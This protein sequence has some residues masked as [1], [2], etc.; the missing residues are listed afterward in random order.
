MITIHVRYHNILQRGAGT[1]CETVELP[2]GASLAEALRHLADQH[3]AP[4]REMLL[5]SDGNIASYLVIFRNGQLIGQQ[6]H[7]LPLANDDELMLFLA[8]S[9]G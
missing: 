5:G 6:Q 3:G 1:A 8:I 2:D 4:L 9:G 7:Q